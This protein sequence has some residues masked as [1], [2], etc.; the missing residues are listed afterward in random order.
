MVDPIRSLQ[1]P[2]G[3]PADPYTSS[4]KYTA[5]AKEE[6]HSAEE[7]VVSLYYQTT[8]KSLAASVDHPEKKQA[9][10]GIEK[11]AVERS[12]LGRAKDWLWSI[13]GWGQKQPVSAAE[14][15]SEAADNNDVDPADDSF[16]GGTPRLQSPEIND[17]KRL[18]QA[19]SNLNQE[20][21]N[22]LKEIAEFEDEM[23]KSS[24]NN[25]DKFI[26]LQLI[27]S[28]I[29]QK[30]LKESGILIAHERFS[31]LH[32]KN[33]E[34]KKAH[35]ALVDAIL[36]ENKA[37]GVIKWINISLTGITIGGTAIAFAV[38]GPLGI[39]AVGLPL[40]YIGKGVTT[41]TNGILKHKTD[42]KTGDLVLI[43]QESKFNTSL[44]KDERS[45]IQISDADITTLLKQ[46]KQHLDNQARSER[47][48]FGRNS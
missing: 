42:R 14:A 45:V 38:G 44:K 11:K 47:A 21:V 30:K 24:S 37:R 25:L 16:A 9:A 15:G 43:K 31:A 1:S 3:W 35:F 28:S 4:A 46:I 13:F 41:L 34:L 29:S 8:L 10:Q 20:L 2:L 26:F 7:Q 5:P 19:I 39:L 12:L 48:S 6:L 36:A 22:R 32:K 40:S 18:S 27:N 23:R 33:Q 17:K